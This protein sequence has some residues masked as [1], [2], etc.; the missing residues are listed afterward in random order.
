MLL[1]CERSPA[2]VKVIKENAESEKNV[3][4]MIYDILLLIGELQY[5][6]KIKGEPNT[7]CFCKKRIY[8]GNY[9]RR[10]KYNGGIFQDSESV[11]RICF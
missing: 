6:L 2:I 5:R 3:K 11:K 10:G 7:S 1:Y 9:H 4:E 8:F